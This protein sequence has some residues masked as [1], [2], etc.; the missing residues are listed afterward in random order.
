[1][2]VATT[3][4]FQIIYSLYEHEYLGYLFESF[5]VQINSKGHLTLQHQNISSK[6]AQEFASG[7]DDTDFQLVKLMDEIQQEVVLR[8][9]Y[10]KKIALTDFFLKIYDP[11][12]GDKALQET[13]EQYIEHIRAE[14]LELMDNKMLFIMGND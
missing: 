9:F 3:Q 7:L 1:M 11:Q 14:I 8:K 2:K 5:V 10:N 6:N 4:P 12:K 13:I